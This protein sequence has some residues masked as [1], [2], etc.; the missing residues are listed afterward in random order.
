MNRRG[1]EATKEPILQWSDGLGNIPIF[2]EDGEVPQINT[3]LRYQSEV[4][5]IKNQAAT[6]S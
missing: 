6:V 5:S 2:Q 1:V 3:D 4:V